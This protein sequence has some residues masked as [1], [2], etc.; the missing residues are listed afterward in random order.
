MENMQLGELSSWDLSDIY[1]NYSEKLMLCELEKA[2]K[3][4]QSLKSKK[5][6]LKD[7]ISINDF[8]ELLN[9]FEELEEIEEKV[10]SYN[11]L[12]FSENTTNQNTQ[13][14]IDLSNNVFTKIDNELL[15]FDTWFKEL[16][17][18]DANRL[19]SNS[20]QYKKSLERSRKLRKYKLSEKEELIC[21]IKDS[22]FLT[23]ISMLYDSFTSSFRFELEVDS[24]KQILTREELSQYFRNKDKDVRY[25]AYKELYRIYEKN[26]DFISPIYNMICKNI[27]SEDI[28][29]RGFKSPINIRNISNE[30][31]D[32]SIETL[33]NVCKEN[34]GIFHDFFRLKAKVLGLE[35]LNRC[36]IYAPY[37]V[38]SKYTIKQ[39]LETVLNSYYDFDKG[40]GDAI[41]NLIEKKH[42]HSKKT[43]NKMFGAFCASINPSILPYVLINYNS[44]LQDTLT[45]AHELGH[46]FH[47]IQS[48][49]QPVEYYHSAL[50]LA[51]TASIF[52]ELLVNEKLLN[53]V[54]TKDEKIS[55]LMSR[56]DDIYASVIRQAY[57]VL[58][59]KK[60]FEMIKESKTKD[61]LSS[62][63]LNN[64]KEQFGD[65]VILE[66]FFKYEW[67][68][69]PHIFHSPFYCYAYSFGNLIV[70]S[71]FNLYKKLGKDEFKQKYFKIL[72]MGSSDTPENILKTV[73]FDINS[74][75]FWNNAFIE[76]KHYLDELKELVD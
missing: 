50:P 30:I 17:D 28:E 73:G 61:D 33:L 68:A 29:L 51:E 11:H 36:D 53:K 26:S 12:L 70:L 56:L 32:E 72:S 35:K 8:L 13:R 37:G 16:N 55:L 19:I 54:K 76:I 22:N 34:V 41:S 74:K 48:S 75:E 63:Y 23:G 6:L 43:K 52:G 14:L 5:D 27:I 59:E 18:N 60:A 46:A 24:K 45:I 3:I 49:I 40:M 62:E 7:N 64:L 39:A 67:L 69:I 57:F 2:K 20:G 38:E 42:I 31:N 25:N 21:N 9:L 15:F 4:S 44:Q 1:E 66:D 58:F 65:S 71:L 10:S 47:S